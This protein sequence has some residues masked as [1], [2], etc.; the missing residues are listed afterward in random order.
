MWQL[1]ISDIELY[2]CVQTQVGVPLKLTQTL[3]IKKRYIYNQGGCTHLFQI[4]LNSLEY[5]VAHLGLAC[6]L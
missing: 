6:S 1:P 5:R 3:Q 2:S 4:F